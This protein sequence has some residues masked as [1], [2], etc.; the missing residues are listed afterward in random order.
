MWKNAE[1]FAD[2]AMNGNTI[3]LD[4]RGRRIY[5]SHLCWQDLVDRYCEREARL[6]DTEGYD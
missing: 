6:R 2:A 1:D 3:I 4:K 5:P